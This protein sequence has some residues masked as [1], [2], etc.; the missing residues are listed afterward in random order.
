LGQKF[1]G[2]GVLLGAALHQEPDEPGSAVN[3]VSAPDSLV[4]AR[5]LVVDDDPDTLDLLVA[6][7]SEAGGRPLS[8]SSADEA[9]KC[10]RHYPADVIVCDVAMPNRDGY[11]FMREL[12]SSGEKAGAW[13]PA[14]ALTGYVRARDSDAALLAGFQMHLPKPADPSVLIDHLIKLWRRGPRANT[15]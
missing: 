15:P 9:L 1:W 3:V 12:R 10:L 5:V 11:S 14:I 8:A 7:V 6:I 2:V 13:T 4:G